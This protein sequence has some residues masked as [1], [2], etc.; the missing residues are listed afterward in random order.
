MGDLPAGYSQA[1]AV[2]A[3]AAKLGSS[4]EWLLR[5]PLEPGFPLRALQMVQQGQAL[6]QDVRENPLYPKL[7]HLQAMAMRWSNGPAPPDADAVEQ[8]AMIDREAWTA[9][10]ATAPRDAIAFSAEWGDWAWTHDRWEEAAEA[11]DNAHRAMRRFILRQVVDEDDRNQILANTQYATRGAFALI[12]T[13]R[14]QDAILLLE[15]ACDLV[16]MV[17]AN[18]RDMDRLLQDDPALRAKLDQAGL[19][20]GQA[21]T[22][23]L[24]S[25]G[26]DG[27][28][29]LSPA[30][31][32]AQMTLDAVVAEIRTRPGF[33]QFALPSGWADVQAAVAQITLVYLVPCDK[34]VAG[35]ALTQTPEG[36]IRAAIVPLSVDLAAIHTAAT[37]FINAEFGDSR[38][39]AQAPLD[40]LLLWLGENLMQPVRD[41]LAALE[42][43]DEPIAL[44]P[45]GLLSYL[46]LQAATKRSETGQTEAPV[47][48]PG[49][50]SYAYSA[51]SLALSLARSAEPPSGKGL[52]INNPRPLPVNFDPLRL[53]NE[54][55]AVVLDHFASEVIVGPQVSTS[56]LMSALPEAGLVH[57]ICH[58]TVARN[59]E[60]SGILLLA[61]FETLTYRHLRLLPGLNARLVVLSAC[62]S[63]AAGITIEHP[64]SLPAA[65]LAAGARAVIGTFWHADEMA[66]LLLMS[67]FY[68]L[69]PSNDMTC[70]QALGAAQ[71]WLRQSSADLLRA[72]VAADALASPAGAA[73]R[74]APA[75]ALPYAHPWYSCSFFVAGA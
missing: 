56:R 26:L 66:T 29:N 69:W 3:Q 52:V 75:D 71:T 6:I 39:D 63:G 58:G 41:A 64:I 1:D 34:G 53:A 40:A 50:V 57:F 27:Y 22:G 73:L 7:R 74:Q 51:R 46:P 65:F 21:Q 12:A 59:L 8:A 15:R 55:A 24:D 20:K 23:A 72:S 70:T 32:D 47:F 18:R 48:S 49:Q 67:R 17:N 31:Q 33:A 68:A 36:K 60:Y 61:N 28:G 38:A 16:F 19:A 37:P 25:F 30:A 42:L 4:A 11:Y 9:S 13:G 35:L 2:M 14:A 43:A 10:L 45:F 62:R 54:E 5:T 44:R